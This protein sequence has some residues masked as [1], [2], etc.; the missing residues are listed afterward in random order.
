MSPLAKHTRA[1]LC[2]TQSKTTPGAF[3]ISIDRRLTGSVGTTI[4]DA[5]V[6]VIYLENGVGLIPLEKDDMLVRLIQ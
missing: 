1:F 6:P 2:L 5:E 3:A 4:R